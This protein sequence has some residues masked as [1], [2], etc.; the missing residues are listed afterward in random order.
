MNPF[1]PDLDQ[2]AAPRE[3]DMHLF[4]IGGTEPIRFTT[5]DPLL[6]DVMLQRLAEGDKAGHFELIDTSNRQINDVWFPESGGGGISKVADGIYEYEFASNRSGFF[7][8]L[9]RLRVGQGAQ[10][11]IV[12]KAHTIRVTSHKYT[13]LIQRLRA[14]IDKSRKREMT[15]LPNGRPLTYGY[16]DA[17]LSGYLDMGCGIIN[18]VP[19]NTGFVVETFPMGDESAVTVLLLAALIIGLEAQGVYSIDTDVP[20]S[21]GGNS[22]TI[23]HLGK[24]AQLL[25]L[26]FLG[27]FQ[28]LL[29]QFKQQY[30]VK[31]LALVQMSQSWTISRFFTA[32][33]S[34]WF[35]RWGLG[36]GPSGVLPGVGTV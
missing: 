14:L 3:E 11:R 17:A 31:G 25:A 7:A 8:A 33:P 36:I 9:Y 22:L 32:V 10:E 18:M 24:I 4:R 2:F 1:F 23:D 19:P 6:G 20:Y 13:F 21:F 12:R 35:S 30:R 16:S 34:G 15:V 26:P 27:N 5:L 28:Q 29:A